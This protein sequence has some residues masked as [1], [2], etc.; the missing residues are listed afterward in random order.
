MSG[1]ELLDQR[2][3]GVGPG[4]AGDLVAELEVVEDVLDVG[5]ETVEIGFEVGR[6]LLT[7]GA[8]AQVAQGEPGGVVEGLAGSLAQGRVLFHH[9]GGVEG[10]LHGKDG[11]L[12]VF[13]HRIEAAQHRH[14]QDDVTVLAA[15]VEVAQHVVGDAPDVVGDPVQVA[16]V[17]HRGL[18]PSPVVE[19]SAP[20]YGYDAVKM[21][22]PARR[23]PGAASSVAR[24]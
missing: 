6:Q 4:Q 3:E 15:H 19:F 7:A 2:A 14:R 24:S 23:A 10:G 17:Q 12:A 18:L 21:V 11:L 1:G 8:G 16:V 9:A 13:Q 20:L 22:H 5:R